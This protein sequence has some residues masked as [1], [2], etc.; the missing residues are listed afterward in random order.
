MIRP[1]PCSGRA[2]KE[3]STRGGAGRGP[4]VAR[5]ARGERLARGRL[6][7]RRAARGSRS[8]A[9]P[10]SEGRRRRLPRGAG[11]PPAA[12]AGRSSGRRRIG[13]ARRELAGGA[14]RARSG[15]EPANRS[16]GASA[17]SSAARGPA[18]RDGHAAAQRSRSAGRTDSA[19]RTN[20]AGRRDRISADRSRLVTDR[21]PRQSRAARCARSRPRGSAPRFHG[22]SKRSRSRPRRLLPARATIAPR[23]PRAA[24]AP[25]LDLH[26]ASAR[27][28]CCTCRSRAARHFTRRHRTC[29]RRWFCGC[30]ASRS[31]R[32]TAPPVPDA[33]PPRS[34]DGRAD[35][36]CHFAR[37]P[38]LRS[39]P[40]LQRRITPPPRSSRRSCT[41]AD[42][43]HERR[44]HAHATAPRRPDPRGPK[45]LRAIGLR[46][47][48]LRAISLRAIRLCAI[49]FFAIRLCAIDLFAIRLFARRAPRDPPPAPVRAPRVRLAPI[50]RGHRR[51][52]PPRSLRQSIA[53]PRRAPAP[54]SP[55]FS[56]ST[57]R[58]HRSS[59]RA[60][61]G[62]SAPPP[63]RRPGPLA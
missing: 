44:P 55:G 40:P 49:D 30:I 31:H 61:A 19:G 1:N 4:H 5:E 23:P 10:D 3:A 52:A 2:T 17:P 42:P 33:P 47:I 62:S 37:S 35:P 13:R 53:L 6:S 29:S 25:A 24:A 22:S 41:A 28:R 26:R 20:S 15:R 59:G 38:A 45:R 14:A 36:P 54:A 51:G 46:A 56:S 11:D 16:A 27:A 48:G 21:G 18:D 60:P 50:S 8:A 39:R 63:R 34:R 43:I 32:S 57:R 58:P 12:T 9:E 7:G